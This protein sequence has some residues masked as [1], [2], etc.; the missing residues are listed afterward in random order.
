M[1]TRR[2]SE[3]FKGILQVIGDEIRGLFS[4]QQE[5]KPVPVRVHPVPDRRKPNNIR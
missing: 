5:P 1:S 4:Q 3:A 2:S